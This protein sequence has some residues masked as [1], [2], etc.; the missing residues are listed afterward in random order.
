MDE[1]RMP[2]EK[3]RIDSD[4]TE[5]RHVFRYLINQKRNNFYK[6]LFS[7]PRVSTSRLYKRCIYI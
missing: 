1:H 4:V 2:T 3:K 7:P 5:L 6:A